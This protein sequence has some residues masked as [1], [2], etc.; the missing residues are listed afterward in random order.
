M[1][2]GGADLLSSC[3]VVPCPP[4]LPCA[5][6]AKPGRRS[7]LIVSQ[8]FSHVSLNRISVSNRTIYPVTFPSQ[9]IVP[10]PCFPYCLSIDC[11]LIG[12]WIRPVSLPLFLLLDFSLI[13]MRACRETKTDTTAPSCPN[14]NVFLFFF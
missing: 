12:T 10:G 13:F 6:S 7:T 8:A 14:V 11:C 4:V 2:L 5:F 9:A 3:P 1:W